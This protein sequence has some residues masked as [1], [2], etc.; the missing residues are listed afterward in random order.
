MKCSNFIGEALDEA[1][2]LGYEEV[3]LAGHMGKLVKLAGGI[4]NTHSRQADCRRELIT[5][6]AA[7]CGGGQ[8]LCRQLMDCATTDACLGLLRQAGLLEAVMES[9]TGEIARHLAR[10]SVGMRTGAVLFSGEQEL[11]G[12]TPEAAEM[13]DRWRQAAGGGT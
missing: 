5:A 2:A 1:A 11:L 4:M 7:V 10:R 8:A 9:L 3:L 13:I 6:H 12:I